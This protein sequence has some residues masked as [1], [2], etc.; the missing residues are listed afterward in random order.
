MMTGGILL[1]T[2]KLVPTTF[3]ATLIMAYEMHFLAGVLF[4]VYFLS[5]I[6]KIEKNLKVIIK[7]TF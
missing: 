5:I 7:L 2:L 6:L 4:I 3:I 1:S